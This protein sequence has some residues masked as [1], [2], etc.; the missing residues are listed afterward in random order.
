MRHF[1][2]LG[3]LGLMLLGIAMAA[4]TS[5]GWAVAAL[6]LVVWGMSFLALVHKSLW[7]ALVFW[8]A[9]AFVQWQVALVALAAWGVLWVVKAWKELPPHVRRGR[10]KPRKDYNPVTGLPMVGGVD[11][12]GNPY[13]ADFNSICDD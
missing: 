12:D 11:T 2:N 6:P 1:A 9:V 8:G 13:M 10:Y 5:W 7:M 3:L 4:D